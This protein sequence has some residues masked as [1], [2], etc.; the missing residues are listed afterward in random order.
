MTES[1][2]VRQ[3]EGL[4][5]DEDEAWV[6]FLH[7]HFRIGACEDARFVVGER[8]LCEVVVVGE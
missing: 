1:W 2:A 6:Q 8:D 5:F 3:S 4:L 7:V